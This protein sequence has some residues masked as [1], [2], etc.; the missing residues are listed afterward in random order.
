MRQFH[1]DK[2]NCLLI[3][4]KKK[5]ILCGT[6]VVNTH[7][8]RAELW[9]C[10][11]RATSRSSCFFF[12]FLTERSPPG[13]WLSLKGVSREGG[14]R[15]SPTTEPL[16]TI[17]L[18]LSLDFSFPSLFFWKDQQAVILIVMELVHSTGF[19]GTPLKNHRIPMQA[20]ETLPRNNQSQCFVNAFLE[21]TSAIM[22]I[23]IQRVLPT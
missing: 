15:G 2:S 6:E 4:P 1:D 14:E 10:N 12:L 23:S 16:Q 17:F 11:L 20:D 5:E 3:L 8:G 21:V 18:L 22:I 19:L 7:T 9:W 13:R